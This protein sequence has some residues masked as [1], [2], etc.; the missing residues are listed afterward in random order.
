M[1]LGMFCAMKV[2]DEKQEREDRAERLRL[3]IKR[4][5][6]GGARA[7]ASR[8][9]W[10]EN[11]VKAHLT[12]RNGFGIAQARAYAKAFNVSLPWLYFNIG[13]NTDPFEDTSDLIDEVTA[14]FASLPPPMQEAQLAAL[15]A[16]VKAM[17]S[18]GSQAE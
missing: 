8:F 5:G 15:R 17:Q 2:K 9:G 3:A 1:F 10:N 12:G 16:L 18:E 6:L 4:A 13:T 14:L 11:T 7:L